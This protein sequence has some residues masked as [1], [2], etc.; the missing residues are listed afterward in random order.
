MRKYI[1]ICIAVVMACLYFSTAVTAEEPE[2]SIEVIEQGTSEDSSSDTNLEGNNIESEKDNGDKISTDSLL[3]EFD[4]KMID[5]EIANELGETI[6]PDTS[7]EPESTSVPEVT[8]ETENTAIPEN[9][10]EP[11][12]TPGNNDI[13]LFDLNPP[14]GD[15]WTEM[16]PMNTGRTDFDT[17]EINGNIYVIGGKGS[18]GYLNS[19]EKYSD[20]S[21]SWTNVT[22]IPNIMAGYTSAYNGNKIYIAG[23]YNDG[24]YLNSIQVYDIET[25]TWAQLSPMKEKRDGAAALCTD[26]KLYVFGGRNN[27][28]FV[29]SYEYYDFETEEWSLVTSGYDESLIRV[30]AKAKYMNGY[31]CVYGGYDKSGSKKGVT[32]YDSAELKNKRDIVS[33]VYDYS[34]V[35]SGGEKALML[36]KNYDSNKYQTNE[37]IVD[38]NM[39]YDTTTIEACP[40]IFDCTGFI[41]H[42]GYLYSI[43]GHDQKTGVCSNFVYK[44]SVYYGNYTGGDGSITDQTTEGGNSITLNVE[45]DKEYIFMINVKNMSDFSSY[46]FTVEFP[47][48]SFTV[49]DACALTGERD[50]STGK[51]EGTDI[52]VTEFESNGLT[53]TVEEDIPSGKKVTETVNAVRLRAN[54][55]GQ[56][57]ISYRMTSK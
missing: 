24:M 19:I 5:E 39:N 23:G 13:A 57:E 9:A 48:D 43:G 52:T 25:D 28:G 15:T 27:K 38:E 7:Q 51:V 35:V 55:S 40:M 4:N 3:S 8:P 14:V 1:S 12:M 36:T 26:N 10:P 31:I 17:Y 56:R 41:I 33:Y 22:T 44:Y 37:L 47:N 18:S 6:I 11:S 42:N 53:F 21:D 54:S 49:L 16:S 50:K 29:N 30:G 46:N 20:M 45:N 34:S 2:M 32:F